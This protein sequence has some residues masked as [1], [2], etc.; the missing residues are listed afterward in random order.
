MEQ[1]PLQNIQ[2]YCQQLKKLLEQ[3]MIIFSDPKISAIENSNAEKNN[4]LIQL[5][6]LV[7]AMKEIKK[8]HTNQFFEIEKEIA[9]C[10]KLMAINNS[11]I[12]ANLRRFK[13]IW[14]ALT[15]KKST[16]FNVYDD[17]GRTL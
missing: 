16:E 14:D 10:Q 5:E 7:T 2:H 1:S 13:S 15:A 9:A 17:K 4:A 11:I 8:N 3:D 12:Y 6:N